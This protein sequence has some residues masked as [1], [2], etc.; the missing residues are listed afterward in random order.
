MLRDAR[1][2]VLA[3]LA[4]A[5][6]AL[7]LSGA[8]RVVAMRAPV[9]RHRCSCPG[10]AGDH[11]ECECASCKRAALA[12]QASD[13]AAPPCHRAAAQK[14]LSR[15]DEGAPGPH[16]APCVEGTCG[17][18][19]RQAMTIAGAEPFCLPDAAMRPCAVGLEAPAGCSEPPQDRAIEPP[20]PRP[21]AA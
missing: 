8:P 20:R 11:R 16:G 7:A 4:A 19:R 15:S 13:S 1:T 10:H 2:A 6:T 3:R 5:L 12:A 21:R 17:S 14:A 18:E 9:E